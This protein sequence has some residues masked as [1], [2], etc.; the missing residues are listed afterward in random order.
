MLLAGSRLQSQL[1]GITFFSPR[2]QSANAARDAAGTHHHCNKVENKQ[3]YG[4]VAATPAYN[5]SL[6]PDRIAEVLFDTDVLDISGS[7]VNNRSQDEFLADYFGLSPQFESTVKMIPHIQNTMLVLSGHFG[8]DQWAPGLYMQVFAPAVWTRW[9]FEICERVAIDGSGT[10]FGAQ[11]MDTGIVTPPIKQFKDALSGK[12][13]FGQMQDPLKFGKVTCA[14]TKHGFSDVH[15]ALGYNF[16]RSDYGHVG[17]SARLVAPAGNRPT[18]EYLFEPIIG[19]GHH[20]E[21]GLGFDGQALVWEK[22]GYQ[23][24]S[25]IVHA[26]LMHLFKARQKRPFDLCANGLASR[27]MLA[28]EF[29]EAGNYT[30]K[31]TPIIN[32]TTLNCKVS[33]D[34][35]ADML[36]FFSYAHKGFVGDLGY[37]G[38]IRSKE[39]IE[40]CETIPTRKYAIKGI[41]NVSTI[42]SVLINTTQSNATIFGNYLT[43]Q[44][45]VADLNPPAF[46]STS[47]IN[48]KSAA[49]PRIV[50]HKLFANLQRTWNKKYVSPFFGGG[51]EIEFEGLNDRNTAQPVRN[52]LSQ[53]GIWFKSGITF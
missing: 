37:N 33:M 13:T 14:H 50:T 51:A 34:I 31:L 8:L 49:S 10:P 18:G 53:W 30:G 44:A 32:H 45:A 24:L 4:H 21:F 15:M 48:R 22:D 19:N 11:Y 40:L 3:C 35:Q 1:N 5:H 29:N 27:Y 41:Q 25:V 38:F 23:E 43:D 42:G 2:S 28:K 36:F 52:T 47:D 6:R 20:W 12:V 26:N 17:L 16:I 9:D 7:Q 46:I 39:K